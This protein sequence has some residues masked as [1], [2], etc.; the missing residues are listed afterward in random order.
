MENVKQEQTENEESGYRRCLAKAMDRTQ[1]LLR[2][3]DMSHDYEKI[4][5]V[6]SILY[7]TIEQAGMETDRLIS[8]QELLR[9]LLTLVA[10]QADPLRR[11]RQE[12]LKVLEELQARHHRA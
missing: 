12:A 5:D 4:H 10:L 7:A 6:K 9:E 2:E 1:Q 8:S 3:N 11:E